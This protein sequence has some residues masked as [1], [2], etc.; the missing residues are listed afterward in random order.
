MRTITKP[1][2][3]AAAE[4]RLPLALAVHRAQQCADRFSKVPAYMPKN[5]L[6]DLVLCCRPLL[7]NPHDTRSHFHFIASVIEV[8]WV[9]IFCIIMW[10]VEDDLCLML[11]NLRA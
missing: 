7:L 4:G 5:A 8:Y 1:V 2:V 3:C 11:F 10:V 9:I 6:S